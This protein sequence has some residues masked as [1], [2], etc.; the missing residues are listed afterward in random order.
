MRSA[1]LLRV[2]IGGLFATR[3][4][5]TASARRA[6]QA[7]GKARAVGRVEPEDEN[8]DLVWH[9][10]IALPGLVGVVEVIEP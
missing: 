6:V 5:A 4:E 3:E 9:H 8:D 10:V 7:W 1:D 2:R